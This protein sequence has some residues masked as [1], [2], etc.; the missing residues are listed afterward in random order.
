MSGSGSPAL[1]ELTEELRRVTGDRLPPDQAELVMTLARP[2][3]ALHPGNGLTGSHFGGAARLARDQPWPDVD[4]RPLSLLVVLDLANFEVFATDLDLPAQGVLNVFYDAATCSA[5]G[6]EPTDRAAW[7]VIYSETGH[8]ADVES[9]ADAQVFDR[10]DLAGR[11]LLTIPGWAE[12]SVAL[13]C[14]PSADWA[15]LQRNAYFALSEAWSP[16]GDRFG[17]G[18]HQVGGWPRYEQEPIWRTCDLVSQGVS[19]GHGEPASTM[20]PDHIMNHGD[21]WRLLLELG[22]DYDAGWQWAD[23]G[24]LLFALRSNVPVPAR[25]ETVWMV[26]DSG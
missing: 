25:F 23:G 16:S 5:W 21:D 26:F 15:D 12:P 19:L 17:A 7:R 13:L 6:Y 9:P 18:G 4:G 22:E 8:A 1:V 2:A 11:Q 14:A 24:A 3:I 20:S 10:V